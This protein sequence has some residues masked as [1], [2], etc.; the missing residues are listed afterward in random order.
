MNLL[1]ISV[2]FP[3]D[4]RK[5]AQDVVPTLEEFEQLWEVWDL[6]TRRMIPH[7]DLLLKPINLRNCY[8]FYLGH[9]PT[10]MDIHLARATDGQPTKPVS[11][12]TMFE[13]GIDPDVDNPELCH[14]HSKIPDTWPPIEDIL[15]FQND[16]RTR[17]IEIYKNR[18]VKVD[19]DLAKALW[20]GLEH[21]GKIALV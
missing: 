11:Y 19:R 3:Q 1:S 7:E 13:R 16:V 9:I 2:S 14:A 10:F 12:R 20:L 17:V 4:P 15:T 21:E 8:L 18:D 5:Y 6:V